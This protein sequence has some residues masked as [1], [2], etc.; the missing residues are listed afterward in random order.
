MECQDPLTPFPLPTVVRRMVLSGL[1]KNGQKQVLAR[2]FGIFSN[3]QRFL[4]G[5]PEQGFRCSQCSRLSRFH[6]F[7]CGFRLDLHISLN[8][9]HSPKQAEPGPNKVLLRPIFPPIAK[10]KFHPSIGEFS[11]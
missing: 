8:R 3:A 2:F 5:Q 1:R 7:N 9:T 6:G 11:H 10:L 4:Y